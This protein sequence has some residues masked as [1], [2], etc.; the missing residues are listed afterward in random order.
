MKQLLLSLALLV[1]AT[2]GVADA[3]PTVRLSGD[4]SDQQFAVA[5]TWFTQHEPLV[6]LVKTTDFHIQ[7]VEGY[8][9]SVTVEENGETLAEWPHLPYSCEAMTNAIRKVL[10]SARP[11]TKAMTFPRNVLRWRGDCP[12][13][14]CPAPDVDLPPEQPLMPAPKFEPKPKQFPWLLLTVVTI[15]GIGAGVAVQWRKTHK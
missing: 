9:P 7:H 5:Q 3:K 10:T 2:R 6:S 14:K 12:L 8:A 15:V 11:P 4:P 1:C 13:G